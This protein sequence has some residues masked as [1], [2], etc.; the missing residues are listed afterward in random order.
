MNESEV[1]QALLGGKIR[2]IEI[3]WQCSRAK[4]SAPTHHKPK[5]SSCRYMGIALYKTSRTVTN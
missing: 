4:V 2:V 5:F 3:F 1:P